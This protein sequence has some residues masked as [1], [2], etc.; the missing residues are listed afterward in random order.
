MD[1]T[2]TFEVAKVFAR[3]DML[4]AIQTLEQ[5]EVFGKKNTDILP[6]ICASMTDFQKLKQITQICPQIQFIC[7]DVANGYSEYFVEAVIRTRAA[8]PHHIIIAGNVVTERCGVCFDIQSSPESPSNS[9]C[10]KYLDSAADM[11]QPELRC[12]CMGCK[13]RLNANHILKIAP[14]AY[15]NCSSRLLKYK[16]KQVGNFKFC[17]N[18]QCGQGFIVYEKC[19]AS[20]LTCPDCSFDFV[21]VVMEGVGF[22]A[23][24]AHIHVALTLFSHHFVPLCKFFH[25]KV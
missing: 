19:G 2:G 10:G 9:C 7:L 12:A 22:W 8:F 18:P 24:V 20:N 15:G 16:L 3:N 25:C 13:R 5:W 21:Q 11:S 4:V 14:I 6:D 1:T 23:F 17:P